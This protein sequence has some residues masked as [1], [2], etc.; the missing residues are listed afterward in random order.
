MEVEYNEDTNT[1]TL[2]FSN[3]IFMGLPANHDTLGLWKFIG[4][5]KYQKWLWEKQS[6]KCAEC[7]KPL[8]KSRGSKIA[9]LHHDPPL[10]TEGSK[11]IDYKGT[12]KNRVLCYGCHK[13]HHSSWKVRK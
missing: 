8:L 13:K 11:A 3:G 6:R 12:T 1:V 9:Y 5:P 4:I 10:G 2:R 7:R